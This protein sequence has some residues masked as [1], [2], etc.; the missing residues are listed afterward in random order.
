MSSRRASQKRPRPIVYRHE[1]R[2]L[3]DEKM[4][5]L[6]KKDLDEVDKA[7]DLN[8]LRVL[9]ARYL[10]RDNNNEIIEGPK[11][12]FERVATL[13]AIADIMQD[14]AVFNLAGGHTQS[15]E[16]AERY[17]AKLDDFDNKLHLGQYY[18]NKYH[19]EAVIRH[20][21]YCAKQGQ[22]KISFKG[23]L[24]SLQKARW[25]TTRTGRGYYNLMVS[26]DFLPNTPTLMNAGARLGHCP[27]ALCL[28]CR[29]TWPAYEVV[30]GRAMIF[31]SGGGVGINYSDLRPEG[32]LSLRR[33]GSLRV[34]SLS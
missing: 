1:R 20:Y 6:N 23:V 13:V 24:N 12:M 8:S 5:V 34:Q 29:T 30:D 18:L 22:M 26:R 14:P 31:K 4:R 33:P 27:R 16:E 2:K 28:T 17:Y 25:R 10:L 11:Q 3:R 7:F 21:V 19:F 32:T 15:I 9:A